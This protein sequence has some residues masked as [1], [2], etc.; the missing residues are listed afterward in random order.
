MRLAITTDLISLEM[1]GQEKASEISEFTI[2]RQI[3][4]ESQYGLTL[5]TLKNQI[6]IL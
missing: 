3:C 4:I 5:Q 2:C 6:T 1:Q